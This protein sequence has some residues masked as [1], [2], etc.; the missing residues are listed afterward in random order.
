MWPFLDF[1]DLLKKKSSVLR[2][3]KT[4]NFFLF[5]NNSL[6]LINLRNI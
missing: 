2:Y 4:V 5:V 6:L 1:I 3:S